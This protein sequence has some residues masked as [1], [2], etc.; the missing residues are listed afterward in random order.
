MT[1][2]QIHAEIA[3]YRLPGEPPAPATKQAALDRLNFLRAREGALDILREARR[4]ALRAGFFLGPVR[5]LHNADEYLRTG[6]I[7]NERGAASHMVEAAE[8]EAQDA[9]L[10]LMGG[11]NASHQ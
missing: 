10:R 6:T 9:K 8:Y 4:Q 7:S 5:S 1:L 2:E 11:V 3:T